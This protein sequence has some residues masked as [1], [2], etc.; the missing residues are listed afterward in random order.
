MYER[1]PKTRLNLVNRNA[2]KKKK[3]V[4]LIPK[5][6][7]SFNNWKRLSRQKP[8]VILSFEKH[9]LWLAC[10]SMILIKILCNCY[11]MKGAS[12][13]TFFSENHTRHWYFP[14]IGQGPGDTLLKMV[15]DCNKHSKILCNSKMLPKNSHAR[16]AVMKVKKEKQVSTCSS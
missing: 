16:V 9:K 6:L 5:S 10:W 11:A 12:W 2:G 14:T 8:Q 3:L 1:L 13:K 4:D 7:R 15:T